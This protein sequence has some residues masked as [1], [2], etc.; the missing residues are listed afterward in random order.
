MSALIDY[1]KLQAAYDRDG[2]YALQLEVGDVCEQGC[3]Y[4]Y[5]NAIPDARNVL[6]DE[7]LTAILR[8]AAALGVSAIEWLGGEPL[9]RPG[10]FRLMAA[11]ADL[12]L[13][14]NIWTGG[15]PLGSPEVARRAAEAAR[16]GLLSIHL[17]TLDPGLY[18]I[19]HPGRPRDDL[20]A[21]LSGLESVL[22]AGYPADRILNSV[23]FTGLQPVADMIATIDAME[24]RYAV[25]TSLNVYHTYLRPGTH[26]GE[27][28]RFIPAPDDVAAVARR[29]ARQWGM[30]QAPM[31]CVNRQY[32]SATF[33]VLC[34]GRVT[35]CATIRP[36]R[37]PVVGADGDLERIV[38]T[39]LSDLV[40]KPLK[41]GEALPADCRRCGMRDSCWGCRSRSYA[42]GNGVHGKDPRCFRR[43]GSGREIPAC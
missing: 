7:T 12:G 35:P 25:R 23:T 31:N 10:V 38:R 43:T 2:F 11:A 34:D 1:E 19:L 21:I 41:T 40:Y 13:R 18:E 36:E 17:S 26:P 9:L 33:A 16:E 39:H 15:L 20:R 29:V 42:A 5:M 4:C 28:A 3:V 6:T 22:D 24:E 27:L 37:A 32:C 14:N 30:E 8:G